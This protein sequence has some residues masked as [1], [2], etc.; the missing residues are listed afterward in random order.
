MDFLVILRAIFVDGL[1][2]QT[3]LQ[4]GLEKL[5]SHMED[6]KSISIIKL[7]ELNKF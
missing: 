6:Q 2:Q 3:R 1:T 4:S 7:L 5:E